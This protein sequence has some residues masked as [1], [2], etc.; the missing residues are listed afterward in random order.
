[1]R[2]IIAFIVISFLVISSANAVLRQV[3]RY[4]YFNNIGGLNNKLSPTPLEK[5]ESIEMLRAI[6]H[7]YKVRMVPSHY[8]SKSVDTEEDRRE[9]ERIMKEDEVFKQYIWRN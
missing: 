3:R 7:G 8:L 6:Q 2:K 9:V 5:A 4:S 1:M